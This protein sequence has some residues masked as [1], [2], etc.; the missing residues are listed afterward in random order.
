M[1]MATAPTVPYVSVDEYLE[2]G[3]HPDKEYVDGV[4]VDR[5][6]PTFAHGVLQMLLIQYFAQFQESLGFLAV[7]EV[8][9]Q[10]VERARYRIPDVLLYK[11]P[12]AGGTVVD[13][14][15][16]SVIEILSPEDRIRQTLD[17]YRDYADFGVLEIVQMDPERFV[18]HRYKDGSLIQTDFEKLPLAGG[19]TF[20]PFPSAELF[21]R[22]RVLLG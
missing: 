13:T 9:T 8:R 2:S 17:R 11:L 16:G 10:I 3:Y 4:L 18:A 12:H 7:P 20:V 21:A 5:A 19:E 1:T 22:L 6:M 14:P 15:P